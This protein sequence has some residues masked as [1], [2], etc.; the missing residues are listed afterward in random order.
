M[1]T[2][3]ILLVE[4]NQDDLDLTLRALRKS[5]IPSTVAIVRDGVEALDYLFGT[6]SHA[7]RDTSDQPRVVFLDLKLPRV[8]GLEVL[9]QMRADERTRNVPVVVLTSSSENHDMLESYHRGANSFIRKPIDFDEFVQAIQ[10]MNAYWLVLNE[11]PY[12][13][14]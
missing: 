1:T 4:D 9:R 11:V 6:G 5:K 10:Q 3:T 2:K 7:G 12:G 14:R 8:A 13:K